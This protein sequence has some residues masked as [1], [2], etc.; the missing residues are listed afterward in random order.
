M[1]VVNR[2]ELRVLDNPEQMGKFQSNGPARFE[3][4]CQSPCEIVDVR[5]MSKDI[6]ADDQISRFALRPKA[7]P[8]SRAV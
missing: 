3:R 7:F 5:D 4:G 1:F 6:I 2:V 8:S